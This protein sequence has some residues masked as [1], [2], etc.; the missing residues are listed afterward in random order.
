MSFGDFLMRSAKEWKDIF[1][2]KYVINTKDQ[3][4]E[5]FFQLIQ[6]DALEDFQQ[7]KKSDR[8]YENTA[9]KN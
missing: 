7:E 9:Q 4:V 6:D 2:N 1:C 3:E 8:T 5:K